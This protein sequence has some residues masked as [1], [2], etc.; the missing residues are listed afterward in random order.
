M[1]EGRV[2]VF[3][4]NVLSAIDYSELF[5]PYQTTFILY[6]LFYRILYTVITVVYT[7]SDKK[8]AIDLAFQL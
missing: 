2:G 1:T 7:Q 5:H 6:V 4:V 3:S 8:G